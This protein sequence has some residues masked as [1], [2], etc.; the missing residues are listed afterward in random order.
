MSF[1]SSAATKALLT[2]GPQFPQHGPEDGLFVD[3]F[4]GSL[5][6]ELLP[7]LSSPLASVTWCGSQGFSVT[8][9]FFRLSPPFSQELHCHPCILVTLVPPR[10]EEYCIVHPGF[11]K[12]LQHQKHVFLSVTAACTLLRGSPPVIRSAPGLAAKTAPGVQCQDLVLALHLDAGIRS[13]LFLKRLT[14]RHLLSQS[15]QENK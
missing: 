7:G 14:A 6:R 1:F 4:S 11:L 8:R 12:S 13:E 10:A 3:M 15:H 9:R 5:P 2:E